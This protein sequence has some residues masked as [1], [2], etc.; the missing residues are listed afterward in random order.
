MKFVW[1]HKVFSLLQDGSVDVGR[2]QLWRDW[3]LDDVEQGLLRGFIHAGECHPLD[4]VLDEG[5][6]NGAV[7]AI[8]G[9]VVGVVSAPSKGKFAE[10]ACSDDKTVALVGNIHE[11]L[12]ALTSLTVLIGHVVVVEVVTDVKEVA[13]TC[14]LDADFLDG[15]AQRLHQS[16]RIVVGAVGGAKAWHGDTDDLLA[17]TLE[18]IHRLDA[19]KQGKRGVKSAANAD[20]DASCASMDDTLGEG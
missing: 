16:H 10:V 13:N 14:F 7:D 17:W 1:T 19:D 18:Q 5:L 9:H 12:R 3:R 11:N 6:R 4:E 2:N 20:D 8:H 15:D